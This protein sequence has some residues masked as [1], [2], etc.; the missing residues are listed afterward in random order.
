LY[1]SDSCSYGLG[2]FLISGRAWRFR[3]PAGS[4][5]Y[6]DDT[7]NNILEFLVMAITIWLQLLDDPDEQH[8]I[9]A[10]GDNTSALDWAYQSSHIDKQSLY[11]EPTNLIARTLVLLVVSSK[12]C[13]TSQHIKSKETTTL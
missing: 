13:L 12:S 7:V 5:I 3:I 11:Y 9:L 2:G 1:I 4:T 10:L 6:G 8:C